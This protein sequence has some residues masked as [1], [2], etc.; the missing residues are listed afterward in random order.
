[1]ISAFG[2]EQARA[3]QPYR[4]SLERKFDLQPKLTLADALDYSPDGVERHRGRQHCLV[5]LRV[6]Q[7]LAARRVMGR[8]DVR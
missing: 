2:Q 8:P 5:K 6:M 1:V 3:S 4:V 7:A